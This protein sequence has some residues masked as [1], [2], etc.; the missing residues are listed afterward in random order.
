MK[1]IKLIALA[2]L[3][4]GTFFVF[5]EK[6]L[7]SSQYQGYTIT[8]NKQ[9][10]NKAVAGSSI[11]QVTYKYAMNNITA[12]SGKASIHTA[13]A[14]KYNGSWQT[15]SKYVKFAGS[16]A[17]GNILFRGVA[18]STKPSGFSVTSTTECNGKNVSDTNCVIKGS[19]YGLSFSNENWLYSFTSTGNLV[20]TD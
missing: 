9:E 19:Q 1:N 12:S 13:F 6:V 8:L 5:G 14:T 7:A 3:L 11:P 15:T 2:I 20:F 18:V 4:V 10:K 16:G 17:T